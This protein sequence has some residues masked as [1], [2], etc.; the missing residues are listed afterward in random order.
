MALPIKN[1]KL[2]HLGAAAKGTEIKTVTQGNSEVVVGKKCTMTKN[3][4]RKYGKGKPRQ[5]NTH[6]MVAE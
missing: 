6:S 1:H 2:S 3:V 4:E 5:R